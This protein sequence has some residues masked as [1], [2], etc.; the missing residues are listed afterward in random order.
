M[1]PKIPQLA[2]W[3]GRKG[4]AQYMCESGGGLQGPHEESYESEA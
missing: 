2:M 3:V 1:S 4:F